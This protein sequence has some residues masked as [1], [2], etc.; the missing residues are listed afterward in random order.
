MPTDTDPEG[1]ATMQT[2]TINPETIATLEA[3]GWKRWTKGAA[4]RLYLNTI[5]TLVVA[6]T[7]GSSKFDGK[8]ITNAD[9]RRL[10]GSKV[11]ID[12]A[13]GEL[14]VDTQ[15]YRNPNYGDERNLADVV[16]EHITAILATIEA[17]QV[18]EDND[19]AAEDGQGHGLT[20]VN[21]CDTENVSRMVV[22][23]VRYHKLAHENEF[24]SKDYEVF[25]FSCVEICDCIAYFVNESRTDV[26]DH[27]VRLASLL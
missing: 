7:V 25:M 5:P 10:M 19:E 18:A 1:S 22:D 17:G 14:H 26:F 20:T 4:D 27:V 23:A 13:T 12:L 8:N 6:G 11:Y 16:A 21:H 9:A 24:G 15:Y 3:N 2:I